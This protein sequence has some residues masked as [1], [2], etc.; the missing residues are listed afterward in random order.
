M[1]DVIH[2]LRA[3]VLNRG[4]TPT[5]QGAR[6]L[7]SIDVSLVSAGIAALAPRWS[8]GQ[9]AS[10]IDHNRIDILKLESTAGFETQ[11]STL[12]LIS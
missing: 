2:S 10:H 8:C 4:G 12:G 6:G 3:T 11:T 5:F 9:K 1:E 7:S